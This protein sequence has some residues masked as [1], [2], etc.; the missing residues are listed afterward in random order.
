MSP[1]WLRH[2][3]FACY[4]Q[5]P[6]SPRCPRFPA[7][8]TWR[9]AATS[10]LSLILLSGCTEAN[11]SAITSPEPGIPAGSPPI[12]TFSN[13]L[14]G[15]RLFVEPGSHAARQA[16]EWRRSRPADAA[17]MDKIAAQSH[18]V[19][20]VD[21]HQRP[22]AAVREATTRIRGAGAL[23]VFV[24]YRIPNRD[25]GQH[26]AGGATGAA[27]YQAW[28]GEVAAGIGSERAMVVLEPD[29]LAGMDCLS[30]EHRTARLEQIRAAVRKLKSQGNI[31]VYI[32][33]GNPG[34]L[35]AGEMADRLLRA[36][37]EEADGFALNVANFFT[38]E[39]NL[40]Y[41][42]EISSLV[43]GKHFVI[44]SSRNGAGADP[45]RHWCNP[46]NRALG[47]KPTVDTGHS[48]VDGFLWLHVPGQSD[49]QCNGGP[50][51]GTWWADYALG[52]AQRSNI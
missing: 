13:P 6:R 7:R 39:E 40:G 52:L 12:R 23:P 48:L 36:G 30:S 21:Y 41:G 28:I 37:V 27:E 15:T 29:A 34:W 49:G 32:D 4:F 19:W 51:P 2:F 5:M 45:A 9:N 17:Q 31:A 43:G 3:T 16:A 35:R 1:G 25:C 47:T 38:N 20:F 26:S 10:A 46:S 14:A 8:I 44:D 24:L 11:A 42:S 33:A 50:A 22:Y 18:A